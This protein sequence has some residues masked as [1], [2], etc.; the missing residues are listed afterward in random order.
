M[1]RLDSDLW[2][3]LVGIPYE[4]RGR[5]PNSYDCYG[6][7][8]TISNRRGII[9]PDVIY[10]T[11]E[12]ERFRLIAI[13]EGWQ[14]TDCK[15]GAIAVFRN[16]TGATAHCGVMI[17]DDCFIHSSEDHGQVVLSKLSYLFGKRLVG[18]YE[19]SRH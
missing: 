4:F 5:G 15:P 11:D 19:Y 14:K 3:D 2:S 12:A 6:L 10:S 18:F 13:A 16:H 1:G 9:I 17:D 7:V 8:L